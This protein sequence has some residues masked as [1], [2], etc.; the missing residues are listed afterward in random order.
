[1]FM[2]TCPK[3]LTIPITSTFQ[4]LQ[5]HVQSYLDN[6]WMDAGSSALASGA[7]TAL[8]SLEPFLKDSTPRPLL[9]AAICR[10]P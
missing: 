10:L 4:C 7:G 8:D 9:P 6:T 2:L 5:Q 3:R 1:M